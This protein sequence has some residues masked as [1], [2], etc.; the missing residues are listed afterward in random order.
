MLPVSV[1]HHNGVA[2]R[3]FK[4]GA[5]R[6]FFSKVSAQPHRAQT[7]KRLRLVFDSFPSVVW[8]AVVNE[9]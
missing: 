7:G 4:A 5:E 2:P 8:R 6:Q 9:N 1:H 3:A